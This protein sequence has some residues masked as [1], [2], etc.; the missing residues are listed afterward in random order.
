M[1]ILFILSTLSIDS[2]LNKPELKP[3]QVGIYFFDLDNDSVI[4]AHNDQKV[5]IPASN[6]KIVTTGAALYF[7][8]PD[9]RFKTHL[10]LC[11]KVKGGKL[12]GDV[13]I[14]GGGDPQ[15]SLND[16]AQFV[17]TITNLGIKEITGDIIVID[18]YFTDERLPTGWAWHYLDARYAPEISALSMNHNC[19]NVRME[20]TKIGD[21]A[22]VSI[23]PETKYVKLINKMKTKTGDDSIIIYRRPEANIIYTEGAIGVYHTKNIEVAV[24]DPAMFVGSYFAEILND[25][26]TKFRGRVIRKEDAKF[27][28]TDTFK[29]DID[30]VISAPLIDI[31]KDINTESVNLNAEILIKTLGACFNSEGSFRSGLQMVKRFLDTCS[32]DTSMVLLSDGSGLSRHNLISPYDLGL[33]LKYL[34]CSQ[35]FKDINKLLL[36]V[37]GQ[38]TL[39]KRFKNFGYEL[40]AKTGTLDAVSCLSGYLKIDEA[41]YCFSMM[42]NNFICPRET[43]EKVQEQILRAFTEQEEK[44][45]KNSKPKND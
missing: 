26:G 39:E 18:E 21:Y 42:F 41:N 34:Y 33:V 8:G 22:R 10:A 19:V 2:F 11:G 43:V 30:S 38:G 24:K 20:A 25:S 16:L 44:T 14:I 3:A 23:E 13:V 1:I 15:F 40:R 4:Y 27:A 31:I 6:M 28:E 35:I 45:N 17:S 12:S 37:P 36:P 29:M 32:V 7:L 9:Y 5:F